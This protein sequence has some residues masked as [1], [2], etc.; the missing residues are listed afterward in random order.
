MRVMI[1]V[2]D[3]PCSHAAVEFVSRVSW[4]SE[5]TVMVVSSVA[6]PASAYAATYAPANIELG[7]WLED[8]TKYHQKV[9]S[10]DETA[11]RSAGLHVTSRVLQ[12]DPRE[13]LVEEA[14]RERTDLVVVGSHGR[15]GLDRLLMGSVAS[16]V[17]TH[18]P[19]SV[20]VVKEGA[21]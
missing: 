6:L 5:T 4:P 15:T 2:D 10:R 1:G 13:T 7:V 18:A 3:S 17:V 16:H 20:L 14:T 12:G 19:C 11:L 8:L 21:K 9:V